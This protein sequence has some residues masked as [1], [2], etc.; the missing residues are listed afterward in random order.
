M[1]NDLNNLNVYALTFAQNNY[2]LDGN[3]VTTT[4]VDNSDGD[5]SNVSYTTT[6]NCPII[7]T[8]LGYIT[9]DGEMEMSLQAHSP[10][11]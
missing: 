10:S 2:Q 7:F 5:D 11:A 9:S 3:S 8:D 4:I 1:V 6:I